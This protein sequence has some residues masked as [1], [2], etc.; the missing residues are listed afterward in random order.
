MSIPLV[1]LAQT[2]KRMLCLLLLVSGGCPLLALAAPEVTTLTFVDQGSDGD[3]RGSYEKELLELILDKTEQQYGSY[4]M[5]PATQGITNSRARESM[6]TKK[7]PNFVRGF[8]YRHTLSDDPNIRYIDFPIYLGLLSY[9][10]CFTSSQ[11]AEDVAQANSFQD[12]LKYTHAQGVGWLDNRVLRHAGFHVL[13]VSDYETM[14]KITAMNRVNMFCRGLNEYLKEKE[15]HQ[16]IKGLVLDESF[17]LYYPF[18]IFF[19]AHVDNAPLLERIEKG[20]MIAYR[21]GTLMDLWERH[22]AESIYFARLHK[23][24][25][26]A[27]KNP[28]IGSV[29]ST[30]PEYFFTPKDVKLVPTTR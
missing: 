2:V 15:T 14:F 20:L 7:Y 28:I 5:L 19:H 18:P 17:A 24:R 22:F 1:Q 4:K 3:L 27:L 12:L 6:K 29:T 23:R 26:Y 9:R 16:G 30:F 13:E 10:V 21:D 8:A 25:V 11:V